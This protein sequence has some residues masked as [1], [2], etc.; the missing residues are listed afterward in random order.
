[1]FMS[2]SLCGFAALRE[3][4][5]LNS[6]HQECPATN[7]RAPSMIN[8]ILCPNYRNFFLSDDIKISR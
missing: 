6:Y 7:G 5:S 2:T 8:R 1:M 3:L 4:K